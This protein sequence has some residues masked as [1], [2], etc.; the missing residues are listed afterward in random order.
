MD[1][2]ALPVIN[3]DRC[4]R[5]GLCIVY[6]PTK[7]VEMVDALPTIVRTKDCVYCGTCEDICTE[8]AIELSYEI[9]PVHRDRPDR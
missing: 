6:C 5:C 2:W 4:T 3:L 1:N 9:V 7:A 8:G